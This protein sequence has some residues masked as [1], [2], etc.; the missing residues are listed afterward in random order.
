MVR[1]LQDRFE[2]ENQA[3]LYKAQLKSRIRRS[4]EGIPELAQDINRLVRNAFV[5]L[6]RTLREDIAKDA[7]IESLNSREI[8][9]AVFQGRPKTLQQAV[10]IAIEYEAFQATR[11]KCGYC[12]RMY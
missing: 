12:E 6:P 1:A 8:E 4:G 2:P 10:N 5:E 3:Q 7:Y 9:L 11:Q